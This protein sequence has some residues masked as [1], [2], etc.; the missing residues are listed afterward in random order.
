MKNK[1][2]K[3]SLS[4][5]VFKAASAVLVLVVLFLLT[6]TP[7][8]AQGQ[9]ETGLQYGEGLG[10]G[11]QDIRITVMN[12]VRIFLGFIGIIAILLALYRSEEHTSE[13]QS[14]R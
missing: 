10:L 4:S 5:T 3:L 9:L 6:I 11:T 14:Q 7:V 1:Q 8:L 12:V 13:L 2:K